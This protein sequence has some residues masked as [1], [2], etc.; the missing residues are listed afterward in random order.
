M[1]KTIFNICGHGQ[2]LCPSF[3]GPF[4]LLKPFGGSWRLLGASWAFLALLAMEGHAK[5]S[6]SVKKKKHS[7]LDGTALL[8]WGGL[9][10]ALNPGPSR[11]LIGGWE[12]LEGLGRGRLGRA[13]NQPAWTPGQPPAP[14]IQPPGPGGGARQTLNP[15]P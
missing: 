11:P 5:P 9:P 2:I 10:L 3:R 12:P 8:A 4:K 15:K 13:C 14:G 1:S 7:S 6:I